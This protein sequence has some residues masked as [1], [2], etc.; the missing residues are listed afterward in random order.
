MQIHMRKLLQRA[1][2][3]F[4]CILLF[5]I[6][7]CDQQD[8][9]P[10]EEVIQSINLKRG[11]LVVCGPADKQFG[12]VAFVTSCS[13][14]NKKEFDLGIALLHSFEYDEAEKVFAKIIDND[15]GCA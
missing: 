11:E 3:Y 8:K 1:P 5:T 12:S 15:P 13:E 7:S 6:A 9:T 14:K 4:M 10:S 2:L